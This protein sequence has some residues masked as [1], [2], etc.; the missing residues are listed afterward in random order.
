MDSLESLTNDGRSMTYVDLGLS[1]KWATCNLGASSPEENGGYFAWAE[2]NPHIGSAMS[3]SWFGAPYYLSG[4]SYKDVRWR[5]Y[6]GADCKTVLDPD[7][8]AATMAL[9]APWR[10]PMANEIKELLNK[11]TW[12]WV[13]MNGKNGFKIVGPNGNSIFLPAAGSLN[14]SGN[15][16]KYG[17]YWS[18]SLVEA[19][20]AYAVGLYFNS[21]ERSMDDHYRDLGCSWDECYRYVCR[22]IRPVRP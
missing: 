12:T 3:E 10:I 17:Y 18:G 5:K 21:R 22:T 9:G 15:E 11:C 2:T 16:G 13:A 1:V 6:N 8:D 20:P 14:S 4:D 7:D 19:Y